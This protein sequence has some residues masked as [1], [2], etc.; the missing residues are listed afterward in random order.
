MARLV[1][2][3]DEEVEQCHTAVSDQIQFDEERHVFMGFQRQPCER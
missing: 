3:P 2:L 1:A